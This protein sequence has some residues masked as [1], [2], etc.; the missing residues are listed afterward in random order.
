MMLVLFFIVTTIICGAGWLTR[1][2]SCLALSYYM[3]TKG[4]PLPNDNEIRECTFEAA[5]HLF[6]SI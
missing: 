1:Y 3:M 6:K 5:K 2:V 4:C